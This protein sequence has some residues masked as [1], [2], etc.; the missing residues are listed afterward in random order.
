MDPI[1]LNQESASNSGGKGSLIGTII[2]VVLLVI[3][4]IYLLSGR[5]ATPTA[6]EETGATTTEATIDLDSAADL[7]NA[8]AAIDL[9]EV[10]AA[11]AALDTAAGE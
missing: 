9:S 6:P 5:T 3:G 1:N 8:A 11:A 10:D 2:V 4:G 7:E